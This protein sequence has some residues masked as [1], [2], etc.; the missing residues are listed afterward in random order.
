MMTRMELTE[1][2]ERTH[3]R[4]QRFQECHEA[5]LSHTDRRWLHLALHEVQRRRAELSHPLHGRRTAPGTQGIVPRWQVTRQITRHAVQAMRSRAFSCVVH[6]G[7][8]CLIYVSTAKLGLSLDAVSGFAT[9][10]WPPTGLALAALIL[11]GF[12][13]WPGIAL[14]AFLV[15]LSAGAPLLVAG[16]M[17]VGNTLEAL[18][19]TWL[20]HRVVGF[21]PA[22]DRL[23]D[24]FGLV[25]LAGVLSTLLSAT[26][27][28]TSGWLGGAIAATDVGQAWCTWW[29]GDLMG[30]LILAPLLL[31]WNG[32]MRLSSPRIGEAG[33]LLGAIVA[34]SLLL[35]G[36]LW[37][38]TDP[39]DPY[40]LLPVLIWAALRFG[41]PGAVT[42]TAIVSALAIWG[43]AQGFGPFARGTLHESLLLLQAF[44]GIVAVT[45]LVLAAAISE[46]TQA[47]AARTHVATMVVSAQDTILGKTMEGRS[48]LP[49]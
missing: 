1:R 43:T 45:I 21:H 22:L 38:T 2:L 17:A 42:A 16:G 8:L 27:G 41:T 7:L 10:V 23:R 40:L 49:R 6:V 12:R 48:Y 25:V 36:G 31:I 35:F 46:R 19:G 20:L 3:Q 15:N 47:N 18:V 24:V 34:V 4:L 26:V 37:G 9:A 28:V 30:D 33:A 13:L 14:G 29:V 39:I 11:G 5:Q 44:M 32:R